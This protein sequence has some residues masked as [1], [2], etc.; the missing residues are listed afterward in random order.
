MTRE[1]EREREKKKT[2]LVASPNKRFDPL[3]KFVSKPL[4]MKDF[5][6]AINKVY[7]QNILHTA[8]PKPKVDFVRERISAKFVQPKK[9]FTLPDVI[10][11]SKNMSDFMEN[12]SVFTKENIATIEKFTIAQSENEHWF[13]Y[14]KC[15][16]TASKSHEVVTKMTKVEKGGGGTVN[17]W[18]WNQKIS[19]LVFVKPNIAA[20]KYGTDRETE[21]AKNVIKFIKGKHMDIK[22]SGCGLFVDEKLPYIEF[23]CGHV[24]KRL[25]WE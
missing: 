25:V 3:K 7:P 11:T 12:L 16:V 2:V 23:C 17:M 22:L 9:V 4:S 5:A 20:L 24:V 6:E 21:A 19:G 15:L 14:R 1:R 10:N 13:E 8:V 18:S